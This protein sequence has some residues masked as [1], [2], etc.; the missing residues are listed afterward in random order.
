MERR[1][2]WVSWEWRGG[3]DLSSQ[4]A[5][6]NESETGREGRRRNKQT[7]L[8]LCGAKVAGLV[9]ARH[10]SSLYCCG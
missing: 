10:R 3:G 8:P 6:S 4:E 2:V 5:F 1:Q 9:F 7:N